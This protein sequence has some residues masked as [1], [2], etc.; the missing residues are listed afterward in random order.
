MKIFLWSILFCLAT[1]LPAYAETSLWKVAAN[2]NVTYLGGTCH[3]LRQKDYPFPGE[4][5]KAYQESEVIAFEADLTKLNHPDIMQMLVRE[6]L[7]KEGRT[8]EKALSSRA[9]HAL[10]TYC[11]GA[12]IPVAAV[13]QMKPWMALVTLLSIELKKLGVN[14]SGVDVY[15]HKKAFADGKVIETL[16]AVEKQVEIMSAMGKGYENRFVLY[17][18]RD[19]SKT[20]KVIGDLIS[21]WKDGDVEKLTEVLSKQM[22]AEC[23]ELYDMILVKRNYDWLEEIESYLHTP[24]KELVLVGVAHLVGED[25]LIALLEKRGYRVEKYRGLN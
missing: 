8:L 5:E 24:E 23:P 4:F 13:N 17:S 12:G 10:K 9:Y 21:M 19:L 1:G 2:G 3:V 6:G 22:K 20:R 15:F 18:V 11:E 25:G 16:E 14:E 7:Y